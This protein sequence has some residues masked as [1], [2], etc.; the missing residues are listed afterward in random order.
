MS[1]FETIYLGIV[2]GGMAAFALTLAYYSRQ[3]AKMHDKS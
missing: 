1:T 3:S 2:I